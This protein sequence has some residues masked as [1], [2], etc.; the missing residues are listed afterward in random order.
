MQ[1]SE[2]VFQGF[3]KLILNVAAIARL[4]RH[5]PSHLF[6]QHTVFTYTSSVETH[7]YRENRNIFLL[8]FVYAL[9]A[10]D[11][12]APAETQSPALGCRAPVFLD[13]SLSE[14]VT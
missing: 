8:E 1:G 4:G 9:P 11:I 6:A 7:G 13:A 14:A 10:S 12:T 3:V 5:S 2:R